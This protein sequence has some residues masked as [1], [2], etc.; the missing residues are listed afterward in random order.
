MS[1]GDQIS[2]GL[3]EFLSGQWGEP[4]LIENL[5]PASAGARRQNLFFEAMRGT[6]GKAERL[7][8]VATITP[9]QSMQVMDVEVEADTLRLA[10]AAGTPVAHVVASSADASF[11]GG[12]FFIT[13]RLAGETIPRRVLR[14]VESNP[15]LGAKLA[16]QCGDALARLHATD[17]SKGRAEL[18]R[19]GRISPAEQAIAMTEALMVSLLQPSPAYALGL[20]WLERHLPAPPDRT[21]ILH[22]DFRNGNIIVSEQGLCAALDW[23]VAKIGDSMEDLAWLCMRM[24][25]FRNDSL[26]VGGFGTAA[27]LRAG[28][29]AAGGEWRHESFHWWK[30]L[31]TLRWGLGL[32]GQAAAHLNGSVPSIVM[33][34][35]GRRVAELEYDTL[36]LIRGS[37]TS[38]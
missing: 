36:M 28:Y 14:L 35:S 25:R 31:C 1:A 12:P 27:D 9:N 16:R 2:K 7:R 20:R 8:L 19:P 17:P 15:G 37:Y 22:G 29:E 24:W 30:V 18:A 13:T 6:S 33:A 26:E 23:E 34:A 3:A 32:A 4:V 10:E 21:A 38:N 11:V 5:Q